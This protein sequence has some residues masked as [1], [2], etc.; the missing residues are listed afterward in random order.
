MIHELV[1]NSAQNLDLLENVDW[2][3]VP[4]ANPDGHAFAHE[5]VSIQ[6]ILL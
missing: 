4:I 5:T 2:I 1:A 6:L 3:I